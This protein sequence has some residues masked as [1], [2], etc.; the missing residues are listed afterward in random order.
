MSKPSVGRIV[1][2]VAHGT[3][4]HPDGTQAFPSVMRAAFITEVDGDTDRVGLL[5]ISPTGLHF[6]S[7]ADG[8]AEY[9][10]GK[11]APGGTWQW[12]ERD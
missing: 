11:T 9:F 3:P 2:Y 7:L 4:V 6:H 8:G 12:P 10:A 5:V 1:R